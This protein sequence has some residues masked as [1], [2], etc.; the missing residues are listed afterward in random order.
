M[1]SGIVNDELE[2]VLRVVVK[3]A[4][5]QR[6]ITAII[7]T[8]FNGSLTLPTSL[9]AEL[10]LPWRSRGK[11]I[12]ANGDETEFDI[13]AAVILWDGVPPKILV[14]AADTDALVGMLLLQNHDLH[15]RVVSGGA[16]AVAAI[17]KGT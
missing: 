14:E 12:L 2:A 1:I 9:I 5:R 15:V 17:V 13:H 8:G 4:R 6:R 10:Q 3:G 16:V 7:D 11:A